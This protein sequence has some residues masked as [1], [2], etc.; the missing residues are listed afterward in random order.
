MKYLIVRQANGQRLKGTINQIAD[1]LSS[2]P[3]MVK[4]HI[5]KEYQLNGFEI[6]TLK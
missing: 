5:D 3:A 6:K 4:L 1:Y 2:T